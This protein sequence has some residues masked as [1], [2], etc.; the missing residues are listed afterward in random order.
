MI[1]V[2]SLIQGKHSSNQVDVLEMDSIFH[3]LLM[4]DID[5]YEAHE[6]HAFI[7]GYADAAMSD[8]DTFVIAFKTP[9]DIDIHFIFGFDTLA[10]CH[11]DIYKDSTWDTGTGT[12]IVIYNRFQEVTPNDSAILEDNTV[13]S[14]FAANNKMI[15]DPDNHSAG[16]KIRPSYYKFGNNQKVP[17]EGSA[18]E[19]LHLQG[20]TLHS[21]VYT[22]DG[23]T[24]AGQILCHWY[25]HSAH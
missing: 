5:H 22:A 13:G 3:A 7:S 1:S 2:K 12:D 24:N 16:T 14:T 11:V 4:I 6:K 23:N 8:E 21:L 18:V 20:D 25:E 10:G 19:K 17:G 15:L 9:A